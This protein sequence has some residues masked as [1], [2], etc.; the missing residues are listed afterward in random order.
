MKETAKLIPLGLWGAR[1]SG[2]MAAKINIISTDIDSTTIQFI[3]EG[4]R[5]GNRIGIVSLLLLSFCITPM[6][7]PCL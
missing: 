4:N 2:N 6:L 1:Y 3:R 5:M 7:T